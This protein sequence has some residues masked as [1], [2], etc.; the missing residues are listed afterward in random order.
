MHFDVD[1]R[2]ILM[3]N[4]G[5]HAYGLATP[6]SD[7]DQKGVCVKPKECYLGFLKTF[8]QHEQLAAAQ[9][10]KSGAVDRVVYSLDKFSRLAADCNPNI[11]EVLHV[12]PSDILKVDS[13]GEE[14]LSMKDAFLSRKARWTFA[15]YGFSQLK[16]IK[17][18]R[19][20]LLN[21]PTKEPTRADFGLGDTTKV[22]K[23]ELG[24]FESMVKDGIEVELPK[25]VLSLFIRERQYQAAKAEFDQYQNWK[26]NRNPARAGLESKF[27][28]DG[29]HGSHLLRL[30]KM[31]KEILQLG[32]VLVKRP[33]R[34]E[35][36]AVKR[37][38]RSYDSLVEEAE[39]LEQE[40]A[41][42]YETSIL[43]KEPDRNKLDA[44]IVDLTDRYLRKYG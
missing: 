41:V 5:S 43:P 4:H 17:L 6:E 21:P 38:E 40:C 16:R 19:R 26:K 29:K 35:L 3:V 36:L 37:G 9:Q 27:G 11:I 28:F 33:D 34:E 42:L 30:L 14:L 1:S 18:H 39:Q 25:D 7:L 12:D 31:C 44:F 22:S 15:G 8:E 20:Y 32:K 23:S 13:F 24:A 10:D 2:T